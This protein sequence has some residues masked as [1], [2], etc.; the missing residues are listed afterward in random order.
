MWPSTL[1]FA[2]NR[3]LICIAAAQKLS[4]V[5]VTQPKDPAASPSPSPSAQHTRNGGQTIPI[6]W[7]HI[8]EARYT[9]SCAQRSKLTGAFLL[10]RDRE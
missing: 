8:S 7:G 5:P 4:A 2:A 6:K 9:H 1:E 10:A 3:S